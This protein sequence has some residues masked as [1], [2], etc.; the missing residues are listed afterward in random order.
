MKLFP[1][2]Y[3]ILIYLVAILLSNTALGHQVIDDRLLRK[4]D[5]SVS[6]WMKKGKIPGASLV[7]VSGDYSVIRCYGYADL[8]LEKKVVPGTLFELG[9]CSK[10]FTAM[11]VMQLERNGQLRLDN[12]VTDYLPWFR[13]KY[14]N[15]VAGITLRQLL[16]HTSGIPWET[17]AG[18]PEDSSSG[19]LERTVRT[20]MGT[21]LRHKPGKQF[22]YATVHYDILALIVEKVTGMTFER[23]LRDSVIKKI[24]LSHTSIAIPDDAMMMA[25]GYKTGFLRPFPYVAPRYAGNNAAGYVISNATDMQEWLRFQ[26][27]LTDSET[28]TVAQATQKRDETVPLHNMSSYAMGWNVSLNGNEEIYHDGLN[29]NFS[30]YLAF[31]KKRQLGVA[32]LTNSGSSYTP[33]IGDMVL[34]ILAA[35]DI[36]KDGFSDDRSDSIYTLICGVL[37]IYIMLLLAGLLVMIWQ[38]AAGKRKRGDRPLKSILKL[39]TA[40]LLG[41]PFLIGIYYIPVVMAGFNWDAAIVWSPLSFKAM[42]LMILSAFFFSY[43]AYFV[44]LLF[45]ATDKLQGTM[46]RVVL[47][48]VF[49]G[50]ANMIIIALVTSS[51]NSEVELKYLLLYYILALSV[52]LLG[53]RFVQINLT[54]MTRNIVFELRMKMIEKIFSTSYQRFEKMDSGRIYTVLNDDV[55]MIGESANTVVSLITSIFTTLTAFLYLAV[56]S[57]WATTLTVTLIILISVIYYFV[58][59]STNVYFEEARETRNSFINLVN[60]MIEGFKEI[61]LHRKKK[62]EY[63]QDIADTADEYRKKISI[64]NIHFVNAFLVGESLLV[65]LLG[66][67]AFVIPK[68]FPYVQSHVVISFVVVLLYLIAPVNEI[69]NSVPSIMQL[70]VAWSRIQLFLNEIPQGAGQGGVQAAPVTRHTVFRVDGLTFQYK[71]ENDHIDFAIG[72][73]DFTVKA[74]EILFIIGGNGSGKTTLAKLLTGLYQPDQGNIYLDDEI[75]SGEQLSECFSTVFSPAYLFNKLYNLDTTKKAEE[76]KKYLQLL[77][78]TDKVTVNGNR[79]STIK[80]SGGQRKR[81]A[82]LQCYLEDSPVYLFDEWAADQ[83]PAYRNFFYRRLLPEMKM[84]GKIIIAITHD[85]HYFDIADTVLEMNQ[86]QLRP[87]KGHP[88]DI[89]TNT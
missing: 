22:E 1:A 69:L 87:W 18:I 15:V 62:A 68:I 34:K 72:P 64:A 26:M 74:G 78:L 51:I 76:I 33:W 4:I 67:V 75:I 84:A 57:F 46:P 24:G 2:H 29:P 5:S 59:K 38:L 27:G 54:R 19:A 53:R 56:I 79:Y 81:L 86:G 37:A 25:T 13:M 77:H 42:I 10:A 66:V 50:I 12:K 21:S 31:R 35:D 63:K 23:Y 43:L 28:Y 88:A 44:G 73:V 7:L 61:S 71:D 16:H 65:L 58:S 30:S 52:Y 14:K 80:L 48:S 83:D 70:K 82:L 45:P 40:M 32:L 39:L 60:G 85:D 20:V 55:T 11:A 47:F 41:V 36:D 6:I 9:S 89:L 8:A 49:S 17:I 3:R